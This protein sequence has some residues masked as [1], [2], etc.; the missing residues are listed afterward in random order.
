MYPVSY[1]IGNNGQAS[2]SSANVTQITHQVRH[3]AHQISQMT[4]LAFNNMICQYGKRNF[5]TTYSAPKKVIVKDGD[6][7]GTILL[8]LDWLSE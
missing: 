8:K 7:F 4:H 2:A 1:N 6:M 5:S 3:L